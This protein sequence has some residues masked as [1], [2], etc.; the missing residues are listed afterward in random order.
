MMDNTDMLDVLQV[1]YALANCFTCT[2]SLLTQAMLLADITTIIL[3]LLMRK[4]SWEK[5]VAHGFCNMIGKWQQQDLNSGM[6]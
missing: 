6:S 1:C 5:Y 2:I 3:I 4:R